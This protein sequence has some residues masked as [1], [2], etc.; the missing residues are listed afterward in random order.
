MSVGAP[1]PPP[2]LVVMEEALQPASLL[3]S[4]SLTDTPYAV[5]LYVKNDIRSPEI[6]LDKHALVC[7]GPVTDVPAAAGGLRLQIGAP[8]LFSTGGRPTDACVCS[9]KVM[10]SNPLRAVLSFSVAAEGPF[11]VSK[12]GSDKLASASASASDHDGDHNS[13]LG[14]ACMLLSMVRSL[15]I[16]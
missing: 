11:T 1:P 13:S 16:N 8:L 2:P 4:G 6:L 9:R 15:F 7:V 12:L 10:I 3:S 14:A 5:S